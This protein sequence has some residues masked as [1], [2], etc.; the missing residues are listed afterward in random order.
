MTGRGERLRS[1]VLG[2]C[3]GLN[4]GDEGTLH[5]VLAQLRGAH[6]V[7]VTVFT[8]DGHDTLR[9]HQ[10]ERA[11]GVRDLSRDE[12]RDEVARLDLQVLG[13]GGVLFDDGEAYD[14]PLRALLPRGVDR[15]RVAGRRSSGTHEARSSYRVTPIAMATGQG[16][17]V[18][19]AGVR[20]ALAGRSPHE[21][22]VRAVQ[23]APRGQGANLES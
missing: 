2:P 19:G 10:V 3:G 12:A 22:D 6:P 18:C 21:V 14:L 11:V 5:V 23:D 4:V 8:R 15:L 7:D 17:G 9:R 16:A 20:A 1:G 13:G